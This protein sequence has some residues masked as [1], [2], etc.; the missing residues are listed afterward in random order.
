MGNIIMER[1][2]MLPKKPK[3]KTSIKT[4]LSKLMTHE[5][6]PATVGLV[7]EVRSELVAEIQSV[8]HEMGALRNE[9]HRDIGSLRHDMGAMEDRLNGRID[10]VI[11][12]VHRTQTLMEEQRGENRI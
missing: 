9:M 4:K 3:S 5:D 10:Q 12:S 11:A 1:I 6:V 2:A 8:R 7:K